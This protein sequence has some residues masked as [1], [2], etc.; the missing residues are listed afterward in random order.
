[1]A[2]PV[3]APPAPR[4]VWHPRPVLCAVCT[5]PAAGFGFFNPGTR[6]RPRPVRW[7]CTITCQGAYARRA[8]EEGRM[9]ELT[10]EE[11]QAFAATMRR[12]GRVMES[13][14]WDTRLGELSEAQIHRLIAETI[15]AFREEMAEIAAAEAA[16]VP[17]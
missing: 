12:V 2:G 7:F 13:I 5:R 3:P 15:E 1:M 14:G 8:A 4:P 10:E 11:T 9:I 6:R 16:K 17:F